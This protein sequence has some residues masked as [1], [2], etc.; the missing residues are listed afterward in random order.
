MRAGFFTVGRKIGAVVG[1]CLFF[2]VAVSAT[3]IYQMEQIA[4]EID[5][6]A[7]RDAPMV[8]MISKITT[9][10]LEQ[11]ISTERAFRY[12]EEMR[13]FP[14]AKSHFEN[15]WKNFDK[16]SKKIAVEVKT[17]EDM[18]A[19]AVKNAT[20]KAGKAEFEHVVS[21]LTTYEAQHKVFEE[22]AREAIGLLTAGK[23]NEA[24]LLSFKLEKEENA[25][26]HNLE[27]LLVEI[28]KFTQ[29]SARKAKQHEEFAVRFVMIAAILGVLIALVS[30][31]AVVKFKIATPL[32]SVLSAIRSLQN[33]ELDIEIK[34][35]SRDEIGAVSH[36]LKDF[37]KSLVE[38]EQLKK[39]SEEK[40]R[41]VLRS[42]MQMEQAQ[43]ESEEKADEAR[44]LAEE[45]AAE[46]RRQ[47]L[48]EL[49]EVFEQEVG[50]VVAE[51]T[52][53]SSD[54]KSNATSLQANASE[55]T[56]Q[57]AAVAAA[58]EETTTSVQTVASAAEELSASI[59]EI[60]RQVSESASTA[61][62][63][64]TEADTANDRVGGLEIAAR[65]IGEVVELIND[66]ASQTNLLALNATIEAARAGEAGKGFAVV[67][68]EVK[69][70]ADQTARATDEI[71]GQIA[72]IQ[73]ATGEAVSA[74]GSIGATIR[75]VDDISSAIAAAVDEQGSSTQE[76]SVNI[77]QVSA[78]ADEV[79][80]N[81]NAVSQ[82]AGNTGEAA[83]HVLESAE[84]LS[85]QA[86]R[87]NEAVGEFLNRVRAA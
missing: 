11:A 32:Q 8:E 61:R 49:A 52:D 64:V 57:S 82:A 42:R 23:L 31:W 84:T 40:E 73:E 46:E 71:G 81:I 72:A 47:N 74:I 26:N 80:T 2:L 54:L 63:A 30:A 85:G 38:S 87:L 21:A 34:S 48:L 77:Q 9:H 62:N 43:R 36:A 25:L 35:T 76:I 68:T 56:S 53:A 51:I 39:E 60:T 27:E 37:Q 83:N 75:T 78:A 70:L 58:S 59:Q 18:A 5:V 55:A 41:E 15:S 29:Q 20:T 33:R 22:H 86:A 7:E 67:A 17:G 4:H 69:S 50:S 45:T 16:Y 24:R 13:T 1:I 44:R 65:K 28:E 10:Q 19:A 12:G 3:A 66:I 6:I 79:N 14:E